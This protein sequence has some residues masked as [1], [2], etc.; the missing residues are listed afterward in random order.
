MKHFL[1]LV[2]NTSCL[3]CFLYQIMS[4]FIK[5]KDIL[6]MGKMLDH[7]FFGKIYDKLSFK[8]FVKA[9]GRK[10]RNFIGGTTI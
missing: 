2:L 3:R 1:M 8:G 6:K 7:F 9:S 5:I 10:I 4:K